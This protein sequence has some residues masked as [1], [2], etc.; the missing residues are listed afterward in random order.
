MR[1]LRALLALLLISS[2][3]ACTNPLTAPY[4]DVDCATSLLQAA[5][6]DGFPGGDG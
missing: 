6:C 5:F 3:A 1:K 2:A 4:D